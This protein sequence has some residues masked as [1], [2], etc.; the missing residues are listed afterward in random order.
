M[1]EAMLEAAAADRVSPAGEPHAL[2][3]ADVVAGY[4]GPPILDGVSLAVG[5]GELRLR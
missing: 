3:L 2:V 1:A 4:G 5:A